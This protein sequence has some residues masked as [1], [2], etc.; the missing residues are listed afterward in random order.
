MTNHEILN[1]FSCLL[2][3]NGKKSLAFKLLKH[4]LKQA[5]N[6]LSISETALLEQVLRN[7]KPSIDARSKK[8]GRV[9]YIIPYAITEKQSICLAIKLLVKSARERREKDFTSRLTNEFVDSFNNKGGSIKK[10][11]EIHMLAEANKSF[12]FFR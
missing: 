8:V 9:S 1:K 7:V 2:M 3:K 10:K 4:S 11:N 5:A 12:A 6:I